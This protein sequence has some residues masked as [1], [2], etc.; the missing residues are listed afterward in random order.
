M[1]ALAGGRRGRSALVGW[2]AGR[3]RALQEVPPAR[4]RRGARARRRRRPRAR[5]RRRTAAAAGGRVGRRGRRR[6]RHLRGRTLTSGL[7]LQ[8][9]PML[10]TGTITSNAIILKYL[11]TLV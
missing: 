7:L 3:R 1:R 2:G 11:S 4:R 8:R 6:R 9:L 10:F 5:P